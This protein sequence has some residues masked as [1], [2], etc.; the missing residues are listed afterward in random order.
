MTKMTFER[1]QF[2]LSINDFS[3]VSIASNVFVVNLL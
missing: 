1:T 3:V 2:Y